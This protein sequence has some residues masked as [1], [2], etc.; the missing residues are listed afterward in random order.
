MWEIRQAWEEAGHGR[1]EGP[2]SLTVTVHLERPLGHYGS[3][4]NAGHLRGSAPVW[5]AVKPDLDNLLKTVMDALQGYAYEDD[6]R[7][8]L[9]ETWKGYCGDGQ[10]PGWEIEVDTIA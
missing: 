2:V 7:I 8:V 3:G 9:M 6:S 1:L 5:P 10:S 4:R